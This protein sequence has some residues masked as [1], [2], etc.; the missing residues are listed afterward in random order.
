[1]VIS[2]DICWN[3][4]SVTGRLPPNN[5]ALIESQVELARTQI[6]LE[7]KVAPQQEWAIIANDGI[8]RTGGAWQVVTDG[9]KYNDAIRR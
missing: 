5:S 6:L 3:G 2:P 1:M 4:S 8:P 9:G 7:R